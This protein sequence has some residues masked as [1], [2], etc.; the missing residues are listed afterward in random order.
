MRPLDLSSIETLLPILFD[1][2]HDCEISMLPA[3]HARICNADFPPAIIQAIKDF[4]QNDPKGIYWSLN[5]VRRGTMLAPG[6][7]ISKDHIVK[8]RWFL[9][10]I[11][12][13]KPPDSNAT[14]EEREEA[15]QAMFAC[16]NYLDD[17]IWPEPMVMSSGNGW[18]LLY[19]VDLP[20]SDLT[21]QLFR[22]VVKKLSE[23]FGNPK[24]DIDQKVHNPARIYK[25]PGT[26][27][28]K[29]PHSKERPCRRAEIVHCPIEFN[30]VELKKFQAFSE[31]QKPGEKPSAF[32][33][34]AYSDGGRSY[35]RAALHKEVA[36]IHASDNGHR[37]DTFN[38]ACF[39]MGTLVGAGA[40]LENEIQDDLCRAAIGVGLGEIEVRKTF[41]SGME[42][43]KAKPRDLPSKNG[44]H[45]EAADDDEEPIIVW[46]KDIKPKALEWLWP[47]MI[48]KNKLTTFAGQTSQG[49]TF[50][51][52]DVIARVTA[53]KPWPDLNGECAE[54][55]KAL[56][57]S[58]DD[59]ADDTI[60]PRL[61]ELGADISKVAFLTEKAQADWTL[62]ALATLDKAIIQ[63]GDD[64]SIVVV[65]PP[66][67]YMGQIN[68]HN[69][70]ELRSV[71]TPL[72]TWA[73]NKRVALILITHINKATGNK[74]DAISR[75]IGGIGWVTAV[76]S[77][78]MCLPDPDD[79]T[80]QLFLPLKA[81]LGPKPKGLAYRIERREG[82]DQAHVEWLG[83]V[84]A[85]A[86]SALGNW[87]KIE[88]RGQRAA[89][90]LA[91]RLQEK[92][93]WESN[94]LLRDGKHAGYSRDAMFE[95]KAILQIKA[96]KNSHEDGSVT[97][98]WAV[99]PGWVPPDFVNSPV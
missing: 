37:N 60:V 34:K 16:M 11:D 2:D 58:G 9:I 3:R 39:S 6:K 53:G 4:S 57:I 25:M 10:D 36:K 23:K 59:D 70:S 20:H 24:V 33:V 51:T 40:I 1:S 17:L 32:V 75:V 13:V 92:P 95:A 83:P 64:V 47:N 68:D 7:A 43:G 69:N 38:R 15:H 97:W 18:A 28:C 61:I 44:S 5:P 63:M 41:H 73:S 76:R 52:C 62:A 79:H 87:P 71:L 27:A 29:G 88:N 48:L 94:D 93:I 50:I 21:T 67:S 86:D 80:R 72:K 81:N 55:G 90:W 30:L 54:V 89:K 56:F 42:A 66:T 99:N 26:W 19:R 65:D 35:A 85:T 31:V 78:F 22:Q 45:K 91:D 46:A 96:V 12:P 74:I 8:R 49:K 82:T 14:E 98:V 77:A 84:D